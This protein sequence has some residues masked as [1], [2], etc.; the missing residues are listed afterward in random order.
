MRRIKT[1]VG[2]IVGVDE[3]VFLDIFSG[4]NLFEGE[5]VGEAVV[6]CSVGIGVPTTAAEKVVL[7]CT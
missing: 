5:T 7:T 4:G 3:D 6:G 1:I 2:D